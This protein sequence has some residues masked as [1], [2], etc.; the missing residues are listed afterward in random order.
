MALW[1]SSGVPFDL[2]VTRTRE[3]L[4]K[5]KTE[6][7][8]MI[9]LSE[10]DTAVLREIEAEYTFHPGPADTLLDRIASAHVQF[11][12]MLASQALHTKLVT[13]QLVG[14]WA[15]ETLTEWLP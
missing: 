14:A 7:Q 9:A 3:A 2:R 13:P 8:A 4:A 5:A 6:R 12:T 11:V 1:G 15:A 10:A